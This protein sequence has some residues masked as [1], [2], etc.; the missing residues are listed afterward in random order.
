M[1]NPADRLA[2]LENELALLQVKPYRANSKE[3]LAVLLDSLCAP[4]SPDQIACEP[5]PWIQ[6]VCAASPLLKQAT[7]AYYLQGQGAPF[8]VSGQEKTW[9]SVKDKLVGITAVDY[10]LA[11]SGTLVLFSGNSRGRWVSLAPRVHLALLPEEKILDSLDDFFSIMK[12]AGK[13]EAAGSAITFIT[14]PS[15]TADIEL[16]LVMGA[17]GPKEVHVITLMFSLDIS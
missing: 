11:D 15:R 12:T 4:Y 2:R 8:P 14:G 13:V 7:L 5:R 6:D 9:N 10:A 16:N 3:E 1:K 17:H